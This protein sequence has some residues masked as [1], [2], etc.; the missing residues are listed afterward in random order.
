MV[1][2][3]D[4]LDTLG[5]LLLP[6]VNQPNRL[7]QSKLI[8]YGSAIRPILVHKVKVVV[9]CRRANGTL[10]HLQIDAREVVDV[11]DAHFIRNGE[12]TQSYVFSYAAVVPAGCHQC[13]ALYN[14]SVTF[15]RQVTMHS[16]LFFSALVLFSFSFS[17]NKLA[18]CRRKAIFH[19]KLIHKT[20][21][22]PAKCSLQCNKLVV[23]YLLKV[24]FCVWSLMVI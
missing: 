23:V 18:M 5:C 15:I 8:L 3:L 22:H 7:I 2:S 13:I 6:P 14:H 24:S 19:A 20:F 12:S 21:E 10:A 16:L 17:L 1:I 9:Q 11:I 4:A